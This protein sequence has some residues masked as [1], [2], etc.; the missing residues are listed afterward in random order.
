MDKECNGK[1]ENEAFD[2]VDNPP[3]KHIR[4]LGFCKQVKDINSLEDSEQ[5]NFKSKAG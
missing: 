2:S 3:D 4:S 1:L 5:I